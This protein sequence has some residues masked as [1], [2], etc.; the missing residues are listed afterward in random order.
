[1]HESGVHKLKQQMTAKEYNDKFKRPAPVTSFETGIKAPKSAEQAIIPHHAVT[2]LNTIEA[3]TAMGHYFDLDP[4][5]VKFWIRQ[6]E[7]MSGKL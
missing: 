3:L 7:M 2:T 5:K 4:K 6:M 1:M